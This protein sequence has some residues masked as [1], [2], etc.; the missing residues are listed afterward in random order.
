MT[1]KRNYRKEYDR[2]HG[3]EEQKKRRA[4]LNE[5]LMNIYKHFEQRKELMKNK[6]FRN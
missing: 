3:R 5:K 2:Y 6:L 4:S 1:K